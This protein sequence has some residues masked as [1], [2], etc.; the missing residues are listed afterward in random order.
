MYELPRPISASG[1][2]ATFDSGEPALDEYVR[3]RALINH[4]AGASRTYVASHDGRVVGY[5]ALA[6]A[7]I[8]RGATPGRVR[9]NMPEPI[10]ALLIS[11]LAVDRGEQ[12]NR[13]GAHLLR[14][15]ILR[16][17]RVADEIGVRVILVHALHDR[18]RGFYEHFDFEPSPTDPL[19]LMLL[20]KDVAR[21]LG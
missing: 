19:H 15:A 3:R 6:S 11:R 5:Y 1:D 18:A 8:T 16:C 7:S 2:V 4:L 10:P 12:G 14:D 9:R 17:A 21:L 20:I 13:L